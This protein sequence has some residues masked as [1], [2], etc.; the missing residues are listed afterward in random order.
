MKNI[1]FPV[2]FSKNAEN[3]LPYAIDFA[4][5]NQAKLIFLHVYHLPLLNTEISPEEIQAT[6]NETENLFSEIIEDRQLSSKFSVS[7]K[8]EYDFINKTGDPEKIIIETAKKIKS[9][10][11]IMGTEGSEGIDAYISGSLTANVIEEADCPVLC[12][13]ANAVFNDFSKIIYATDYKD[14]D[15]TVLRKLVSHFEK[16]N[17]EI[18]ITHVASNPDKDEKDWIE[19]FKELIEEKISYTNIIYHYITNPNVII[20]LNELAIKEKADIIV[21]S[22]AKRVLFEKIFN[23]SLT[24]KMA[25]KTKIPL[26]VYHSAELEVDPFNLDN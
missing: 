3:A 22:S 18:H 16:F 4:N 1:L 17:T 24:K 9:G 21:M 7:T 5:A 11:I 8:L 20:G 26:L 25:Y 15:F 19:W 6:I 23:P 14:S 10:M 2:D 13:P 12:V